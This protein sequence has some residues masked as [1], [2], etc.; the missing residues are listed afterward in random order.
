MRHGRCIQLKRGLSSPRFCSVW[1]G[2]D[3]VW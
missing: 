3:Q 2:F 1:D